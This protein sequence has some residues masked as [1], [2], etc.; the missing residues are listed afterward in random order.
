MQLYL[1]LNEGTLSP[2]FASPEMVERIVGKK[3]NR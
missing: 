2:V 1:D 3:A